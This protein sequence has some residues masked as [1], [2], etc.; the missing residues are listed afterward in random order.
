MKKGFFAYSVRP[1]HAG[2]AIE[3][4]IHSI[5]A[6]YSDV[7]LMSWRKLEVGGKVVIT[8]VLKAIDESDFICADLTGL[9]DNVLFELGY[10][11]TKNKPIWLLLDNSHEDSVRKFRELGVLSGLGYRS[12]NN[13]DHIVIQFE[14]DR[15]YDRQ[16]GPLG[17]LESTIGLSDSECFLFF[18]KNQVDTNYSRTISNA[19]FNLY[20][21]P[22][23]VDDA[24]ETKMQSLPWYFTQLRNVSALLAEF[25]SEERAGFSLQNSKCS[26]ICGMAT[27][28][29]LKVLMV[30]EDPYNVP[31]DYRELLKKYNNRAHCEAIVSEYLSSLKDNVFELKRSG[32]PSLHSRTRTKTP[33][34][35]IDFG[36]ILAEYEAEE[37]P[38]YYVETILAKNLIR[39]NYNVVV[40]RKGSGKTATLFFLKNSLEGD[41]RNHVCVIKP[42]SF[43]ISAL[44]HL[45]ENL[46]EEFETSYIIESTWK[47]LIFTEVASSLYHAIKKRHAFS[48]TQAEHNFVSFIESNSELFLQDISIR[49]EEEFGK[50]T[51]SE[52]KGKVADF[53]IRVSEIMHEATLNQ[54]KVHL[55]ALFSR[56]KNIFVLVDNLDKSWSKNSKLALQSKWILGLLDTVGPIIRDMSRIRNIDFKLTIFLRTDIFRHILN[57]ASE[58]DKIE[59]SRLVWNDTHTLMRVIEERFISSL[60]GLASAEDLWEK[61]VTAYVGEEDAKEYIFSRII[62][63]PRDLIYFIKRAQDAAIQRGHEIIEAQDFEHAYNQYS[64]WVFTSILVE[65]GITIDELKE[66]LYELLGCNNVISR[67][68]IISSIEKSKIPIDTLQSEKVDKFIEHLVGLSIIGREVKPGRYA[69]D[70]EYDDIEKFRA[71]AERLGSDNFRVHN[72]LLPHLE[73]S[74]V[75]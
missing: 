26:L 67:T 71:L 60:D 32:K 55:Q 43:E 11:V 59:Y 49:L 42:I 69:F 31:F 74:V 24:V 56:E 20:K 73:M 23:V 1:A 33:I 6:A 35:S 62:P 65:N 19:I 5:N 21:I 41:P 48:Y 58:P 61:Y 22:T 30:C 54:I 72:S 75:T 7:K 53:K 44:T 28:L 12:Y 10:A 14:S 50:I 8:E 13:S 18:L 34:H 40:G 68:F 51:A 2:E 36:E 4:A 15:P 17:S 27:G 3:E 45:L 64:S 70:Y 16:D 29:G 38:N 63:R 25:S 46:P 9:S 47:L 52:L 39:N 37:L 66:F 57:Y